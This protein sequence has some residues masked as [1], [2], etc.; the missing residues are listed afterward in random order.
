MSARWRHSGVLRVHMCT[1]GPP[2]T[3]VY[4]VLRMTHPKWR[5]LAAEGSSVYTCVQRVLR[6]CTHV[7]GG[8]PKLHTCVRGVLRNCTHVYRGVLRVHMCTGSSEWL[9]LKGAPLRP[10]VTLATKES[11]HTCVRYTWLIL[12]SNPLVIKGSLHTC[13]QHTWFILDS[14]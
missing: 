11:V 8:P 3:H 12:D 2:C 13:V 9:I 5:P 14:N 1:R 6:N 10:I 7:Y 4:K